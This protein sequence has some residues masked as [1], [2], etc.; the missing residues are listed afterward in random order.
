[1][2]LKNGIQ[3]TQ[4]NFFNKT[5]QQ[6]PSI[7]TV[8][9][10]PAV[11]YSTTFEQ[12]KKL[13]IETSG[14]RNERSLPVTTRSSVLGTLGFSLDE[15]DKKHVK[16]SNEQTKYWNKRLEKKS[17]KMIE[18]VKLGTLNFKTQV[19]KDID[20]L[21]SMKSIK[22]LES[23]YKDIEEEKSTVLA[24]NISVS[25]KRFDFDIFKNNF[26]KVITSAIKSPKK[27]KKTIVEEEQELAKVGNDLCIMRK[28]KRM[29]SQTNNIEYTECKENDEV[30]IDNRVL[31]QNDLSLKGKYDQMI[32]QNYYKG[33]ILDKYKMEKMFHDQI[34]QTIKAIKE[35]K[36]I[37]NKLSEDIKNIAD[38]Y[39]QTKAQYDTLKD[40]YEML[41]RR[42]DSRILTSKNKGEFFEET[43]HLQ[44][45][46]NDAKNELLNFSHKAL[47]VEQ[48][49]YIELPKLRYKLK[50]AKNDIKCMHQLYNKMIEESK[51]YYYNLLREGIDVRDSGLS[52]II[53]KLFELEAE[54]GMEC[55][56]KFIDYV[57][58]RYLID[59][60]K[61]RLLVAKLNALIVCIKKN[62]INEEV[63][64]AKEHG[65]KI[66]KFQKKNAFS[67]EKLMYLIN[68]FNK[69][70]LDKNLILTNEADLADAENTK[71]ALHQ[72][73][74]I[75]NSS[76]SPN[77]DTKIDL[78]EK[79]RER[80]KN[81]I[82]ICN[83]SK[84]SIFNAMVNVKDEISKVESEMLKMKKEQMK[85]LKKKYEGMKSK[86]ISECVKYD[87]MF[88]ALFGNHAII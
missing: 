54:V 2:I 30:K 59:Y 26:K 16:P 44:S 82:K 21:K 84:E 86:G 80:F 7:K 8:G 20:M 70:V 34:T 56:P 68:E 46:K 65:K 88:S 13:I 14:G 32:N 87:L 12:Q 11:S 24:Q 48:E 81:L 53:F 9:F 71:K 6:L 47:G 15:W 49:Y 40:A 57:S 61:K 43:T 73:K 51:A 69:L 35:Q 72:I 25:K 62:F 52:W 39:S 63:I 31:R 38:K 42:C 10:S 67:K 85:Y 60:A 29:N 19:S 36:K 78:F 3:N 37:I 66:T 45:H 22:K 58:Y 64:R 5:S 18:D 77:E 83:V 4:N 27:E 1:M 76:I 74:N 33:I 50:E 79:K 17:S 28:I 55:F 23:F 75:S 41:V